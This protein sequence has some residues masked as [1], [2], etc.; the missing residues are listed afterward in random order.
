MWS[1]CAL[2]N[3]LETQTQTARNADNT[4]NLMTTLS[5]L[6]FFCLL[7]PLFQVHPGWNFLALSSSPGRRHVADRPMDAF[8]DSAG[9]RKQLIGK[10]VGFVAQRSAG[11][12]TGSGSQEKTQACSNA[13]T[14]QEAHEWR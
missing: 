3:G 9:G 13:D 4:T 11:F 5:Y 14:E 10:V 2:S 7:L 8:A 6:S 12:R 1:L